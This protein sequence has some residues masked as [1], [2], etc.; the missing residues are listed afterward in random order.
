MCSGPWTL[1][2]VGISAGKK[3]KRGT[4]LLDGSVADSVIALSRFGSRLLCAQTFGEVERSV[5][6]GVAHL[7]EGAASRSRAFPNLVQHLLCRLVDQLSSTPPPKKE[8]NKK[9]REELSHSRRFGCQ[10]PANDRCDIGAG[11]GQ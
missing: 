8:K 6:T 5:L 9:T 11:P 1:L 7:A 10:C 4:G 3:I 2:A